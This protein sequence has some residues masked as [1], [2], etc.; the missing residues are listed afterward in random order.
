M[1]LLV[2]LNLLNL[3]Q[4]LIIVCGYFSLCLNLLNSLQT[5]GLLVGS[6]IVALRVTRGESDP[7]E[8]VVFI[9]YLAQVGK[10]FILHT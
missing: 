8:F 6:Y 7:S 5:I 1:L 9:T 10:H 2:S 4:S 3:V